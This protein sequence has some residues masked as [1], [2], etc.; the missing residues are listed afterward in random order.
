MKYE[1]LLALLQSEDVYDR[2]LQ[3]EG[4]IFALIPELKA[5]KGFDQKNSW[6]VYDVYEHILHVVA[7]VE[8]SLTLRLV[9]LFHDVGKPLAF[10]LDDQGVGHFYGHWDRSLEIFQKYAPYFGLTPR[11]KDL[12]EVL[13]YYH[14]VNVDK[15][16]AGEIAEM[17]QRIGG[18]NI[19]MLFA[20]K[21]ADL[22]AQSEK[23]HSLLEN[24]QRQESR[25]RTMA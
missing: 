24:L 20:I 9:A 8:N 5:C 13:I 16:E 23:Y 11:E 14:D 3:N 25:L 2:I 15:M 21:K 4:A 10:T 6:H 22:L 7:G 1:Q 18:D 17:V 19:G 12:M